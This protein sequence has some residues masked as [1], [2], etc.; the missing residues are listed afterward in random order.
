MAQRRGLP[1]TCPSAVR[2][3]QHWLTVLN[4]T[5]RDRARPV[6]ECREAVE[7][8][9]DLDEAAGLFEVGLELL[10]LVAVD[11]LLDG[12]RGL[13]DERL[14]LLEAQAGGGAD[15]LDDLDLLVAGAG[16]DDVERRLLLDL[17]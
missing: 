15:D 16:E 5:G 1:E 6:T 11:A 14:G 10:G 17:L 4:A 9:F 12:L 7:R 8:L 13:V 3:M 2:Q